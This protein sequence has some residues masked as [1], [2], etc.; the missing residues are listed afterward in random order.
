MT[1]GRELGNEAWGYDDTLPY[2]KKAEN[3][4]RLENEF[5]GRGGP[6]NVSDSIFSHP[7]SQLFVAVND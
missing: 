1:T 6:L 5:H 7:V 2:F 3:N 4:E